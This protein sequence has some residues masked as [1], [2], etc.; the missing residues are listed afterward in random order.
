M[1]TDPGLPNGTDALDHSSKLVLGTERLVILGD[2]I[3]RVDA[4]V[5]DATL[6]TVPVFMIK[7]DDVII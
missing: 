6:L 1:G 3:S 5:I 7:F 4:D 2:Q